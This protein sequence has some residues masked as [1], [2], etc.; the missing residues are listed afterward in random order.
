[1]HK[2]DTVN[3]TRNSASRIVLK[4]TIQDEAEDNDEAPLTREQRLTI[5][6][7]L[8]VVCVFVTRL[9]TML[10]SHML[11]EVMLGTQ[12]ILHGT[13]LFRVFQNRLLGPILVDGT[14]WIFR[15]N[16]EDSYR[17]TMSLLE[18]LSIIS[19]YGLVRNITKQASL[20]L[21]GAASFSFAVLLVQDARYFYIWDAIDLTTMLIFAYVVFHAKAD[22]RIL[23]PLFFVELLN[24]ESAA[25][26][27]LWMIIYGVSRYNCRA[28]FR[29]S[30][31][32]ASVLIGALGCVLLAFGA[33]WTEELRMLLFKHSCVA[34]VNLD[35]THG[36]GQWFELVNNLQGLSAFFNPADF[37]LALLCTVGIIYMCYSLSRQSG[38]DCYPIIVLLAGMLSSVWMFGIVDETRVWLD[39][40]PFGIVYV[41]TFK[42]FAA[43]G[44]P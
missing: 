27:P 16:Y 38:R 13:P 15:Q 36:M 9:L 35:S 39:Y 29:S 6:L 18:C 5:A 12:G 43:Y 31:N 30:S 10:Q 7:C 4:L 25:Y 20:G 40:V 34:S 11:G 37:A 22:L 28:G 32:K 2:L 1:V 14:H 26:I 33:W 8:L 41:F 24:R 3:A 19:C 23:L 17:L 42:P 21:L 44:N